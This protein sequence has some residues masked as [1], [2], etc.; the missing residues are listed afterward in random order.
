M[1]IFRNNLIFKLRKLKLVFFN[2]DD[3][4]LFRVEDI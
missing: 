2:L 4:Q 3:N 1:H